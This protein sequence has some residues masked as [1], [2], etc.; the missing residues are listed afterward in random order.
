MDIIFHIIL[1][2]L[3]SFFKT[4]K[5]SYLYPL[6]PFDGKEMLNFVIRKPKKKKDLKSS[7]LYV[8]IL[9]FKAKRQN[10]KYPHFG[11][12]VK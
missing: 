9:T 4:I 12:T 3:F 5:T 7:N 2:K 10:M 11:D 8:I 6:Y 1:I